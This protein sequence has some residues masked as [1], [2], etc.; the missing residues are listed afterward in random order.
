MKKILI[1]L[2][3][4]A[5]V[6][7]FASCGGDSEED[8]MANKVAIIL[9]IGGLGDQG[10]NDGAKTGFDM[11]SEKYGIDGV[12]VEATA[13]SEADTFVRQLAEEGYPLII[14]LD[15]IIIDYVKTASVDY[16]DTFFVVLGKGLPGPG[17]QENLI[18]PFT[19]LHEWAFMADAA[20]IELSKDD[21]IMFDWQVNNPGVTIAS[22]NAGESVNAGRSRSARQQIAQWYKDNEDIDVVSYNDYTGSYTDSALNQQIAENLIVNMGVEAFWPVVGTGALATFTTAKQY[23]AF[24]LGC[25]SFQDDIEPGVVATSVL[26]NTTMMVVNIVTEWQEGTLSGTNEYYWGVE[27]GV[28]GLTD[29]SFVKTVDGCNLE[30]WTRITAALEEW[31]RRVVSGEFI[32]YNYFLE[33]EFDS[34]AGE[35]ENWQAKHPG[36]DYTEWVKNGR[37]N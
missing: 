10:Y 7:S 36:V 14:C 16:P 24:A 30:V 18:E 1:L 35:F 11:M 28:V 17:N 6:F 19:A 22:I 29:M 33:L 23:G 2:L 27:S 5:F 25:D 12:L 4:L 32:V 13:A 34:E 8:P 31:E 3:T 37:P 9:Q 15:W 20:M 26:H 21:N